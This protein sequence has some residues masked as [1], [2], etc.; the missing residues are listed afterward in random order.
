MMIRRL[1][2]GAELIIIGLLLTLYG[3]TQLQS[4]LLLVVLIGIMV[5]V[6]LPF[7]RSLQLA[8]FLV[9]CLDIFTGT[10]LLPISLATVI[11]LAI[12]GRYLLSQ[13]LHTTYYV[14]GILI[15]AIFIIYEFHHAL[16]LPTLISTQ[17]F[18]WMLMFLFVSFLLF[19][20]NKYIEFS[21]LR[22]AFFIGLLFST[23]YGGLVAI[24]GREVIVGGHGLARFSGGAG[25]PNSFGLMCLLLVFF[26]LPKIPRQKITFQ[27][28]TIVAVLLSIGSLTVSRSYFLVSFG[29]LGLYSIFYF[30]AS[31]SDLFYR[32]LIV[33]TFTSLALLVL[34]S[35]GMLDNV[36]FGILKRFSGDN[37]SEMTGARSDILTFYIDTYF[38]QSTY[39]VLFGAGIN[40]Y[41]TYYN[42][43]FMLKS[44]FPQPVGPHNT[45]VEI[46]VSFGMFGSWII[47]IYIYLAFAAERIRV[48]SKKT[49]WMAYLPFIVFFLYSLSL[50]NL[51]KYSSYLILLMIIYSVY[52]DEDEDEEEE[53]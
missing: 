30:R 20:R 21:G 34:Q 38:A 13:L 4:L 53:E 45:F 6:L 37:L 43:I 48:K 35:T 27:H 15:T 32:F 22:L 18:R 52:E 16:M 9:P 31:I 40:G 49:Y 1:N 29:S 19:D 26:Y 2:L 39:W 3:I 36:E 10:T 7:S 42:D 46:L 33:F 17:S 8:V 28:L 47:F 5:A 11:Y 41:F 23:V 12:F 25:D 14:P 50:Q 44:L 51:G 24:F